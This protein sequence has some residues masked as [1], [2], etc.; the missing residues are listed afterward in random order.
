MAPASL[1]FAASASALLGGDLQMLGRETVGERG[2]L[3]EA[4]HQDHRA[5]VVPAGA[6]GLGA[7]Q[8]GELALDRFDHGVGEGRIVGDEDRLG[9]GVVLGLG[10][11]VGGDPGRV[12]LG[13]GDDHDLGR[14]GHHVDADLAEHLALGRGH[15]GVAGADD[16]DHRLDGLRAEGERG[17]GLRA[18]DAIDL[19]DAGKLGGHQHQRV[20]LAA[21][22]SA[23]P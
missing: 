22:A 6:R 18:A 4:R 13:V 9:G 8:R 20:Q 21:R 17:D 3:V 1:I 11:Q 2:R 10:E 15:I 14:A 16:L 19:V 5:E 7:R 12:V 23:P